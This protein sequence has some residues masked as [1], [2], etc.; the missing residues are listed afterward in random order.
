[1]IER[2]SANQVRAVFEGVGDKGKIQN[3]RR[4]FKLAP[5]YAAT[6]DLLKTLSSPCGRIGLAGLGEERNLKVLSLGCRSLDVAQAFAIW[7]V[8]NDKRIQTYDLIDWSEG[9]LSFA[10]SV[11]KTAGLSGRTITGDLVSNGLKEDYDIFIVR[12]RIRDLFS[13]PKNV[14]SEMIHKN[15]KE[16]RLKRFYLIERPTDYSDDHDFLTGLERTGFDVKLRPNGSNHLMLKFDHNNPDISDWNIAVA[17][18]TALA[19]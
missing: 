13:Y 16:S 5:G 2:L 10:L 12:C 3:A 14:F 18:M 4:H 11:T 1:M 8:E 15:T 9:E 19:K 6:E 17:Q 7:S